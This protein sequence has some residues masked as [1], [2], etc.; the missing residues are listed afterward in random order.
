MEATQVK[1]SKIV[2]PFAEGRLV[3]REEVQLGNLPDIQLRLKHVETGEIMSE[4]FTGRPLVK[5]EDMRGLDLKEVEALYMYWLKNRYGEQY[6]PADYSSWSKMAGNFMM[7]FFFEPRFK[8]L[9][10]ARSEFS[11]IECDYREIGQAPRSGPRL[12]LK[13]DKNM[14]LDSTYYHSGYPLSGPAQEMF[15]STY[16]SQLHYGGAVAGWV[17]V[18][19]VRQIFCVTHRFIRLVDTFDRIELQ[20]WVENR[21]NAIL[22]GIVDQG[23]VT[24][25]EWLPAGKYFGGDQPHDPTMGAVQVGAMTMDEVKSTIANR[26]TQA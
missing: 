17:T 25:F 23:L 15:E 7:H 18:F 8:H 22:P 10:T 3:P 13:L 5:S 24:K 20:D 14:K 12:R 21:V 19:G 16:D 6:L 11:M 26:G 4:Y 1:S 9:R 2:F